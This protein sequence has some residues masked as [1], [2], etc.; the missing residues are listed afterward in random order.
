MLLD[1]DLNSTVE[2]ML[3][4]NNATVDRRPLIDAVGRLSDAGKVAVV[5]AH[6]ARGVLLISTERRRRGGSSSLSLSKR[7]FTYKHL[8]RIDSSPT[9]FLSCFLF[10]KWL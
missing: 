1:S 3:S 5:V 9:R 10:C 7:C 2:N 4:C 6:C 8:E